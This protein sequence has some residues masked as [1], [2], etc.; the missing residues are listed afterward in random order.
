M[1]GAVRKK[2]INGIKV[3]GRTGVINRRR[4]KDRGRG[5]SSHLARTPKLICN[6]ECTL[7]DANQADEI[8]ADSCL[9][10]RSLM[11]AGALRVGFRQSGSDLV[12][13]GALFVGMGNLKNARLVQRFSE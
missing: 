11:K 12:P 1:A 6:R 5:C 4:T 7:M 8:R 13:V 9:P 10:R 3:K 2:R